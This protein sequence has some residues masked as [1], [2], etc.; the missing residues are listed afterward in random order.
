MY[1]LTNTTSILRS[2]GA[3]I[4]NDPANSDYQAYLAWIE[5]GNEPEPADVSGEWAGIVKNHAVCTPAQGLVALFIVKNITEA[6]I[7]TAIDNIS[8]PLD[9]Y[10]CQIG[11]TRATEWE[12]GSDSFQR[13]AE[14][15]G[16]TEDDLD[17]LFDIAV[18]VKV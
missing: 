14:L 3:F 12:R 4:P 17:T 16:L 7:L 13:I 2:N 1:K 8:N 5:E 9:K 18:T 11:Y 10:T 15:L 6:D